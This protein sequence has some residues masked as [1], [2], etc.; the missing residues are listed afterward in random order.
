M[1][2]RTAP[3]A[4]TLL[5]A[6][7]LP[8]PVLAADPAAHDHSHGQA[9]AAPDTPRATAPSPAAATAS[10]PTPDPRYAQHLQRMRELHERMLAAGTPA[11][12]QKLKAEGMRLMQDGMTMMNEMKK[13]DR[14]RGAG[15]GMAGSASPGMMDMHRC[16]EM[17]GAMAQRMDMME[18]MM[19]MMLDQQ[20]T[21]P[22][23]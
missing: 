3:V 11:E 21:A 6:T 2:T 12:R 5:L 1:L 23:K 10:A 22:V 7:L 15:K 19:Q 8:L 18:A 14:E 4:T 9:A 17:H 13:A 20:A 16:M